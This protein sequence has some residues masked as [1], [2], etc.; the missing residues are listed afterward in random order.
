[1]S[2]ESFLFVLNEYSGL[3]NWITALVALAA[4]FY[5]V[6]EYWL[7][8]RPYIDI[9]I[10]VAENPNKQQGGYLFFAILVNKG[11]YPGIAKI[12]KTQ[13][14]VGDETYP[15]DVKA[16]LILSPGESKKLALI[17]SIYKSGINKILGHEYRSNR[18]EIE[19][20]VESGDIGSSK[21]KYFTRVIYELDVKAEPPN[22][23]LIEEEFK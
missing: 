6:K 17:G 21:L 20:E 8:K 19:V 16:K 2:P 23:L 12:K 3:A 9:E 7:K 15:S 4:L 11:T 14:T 1:M 13:M 22:L 10:A 5:A 18:A